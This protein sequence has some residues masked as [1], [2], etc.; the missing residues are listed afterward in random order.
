MLDQNG[1]QTIGASPRCSELGYYN[2]SSVCYV[3]CSVACA[4]N[5]IKEKAS[6]AD[7]LTPK[8]MALA[9]GRDISDDEEGMEIVQE[10]G[11]EVELL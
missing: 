9:T 6:V 4:A 1:L 2:P 10:D 7:L 5:A 3:V 11:D 8:L